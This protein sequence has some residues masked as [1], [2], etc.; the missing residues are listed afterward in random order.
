MNALLCGNLSIFKIRCYILKEID[1]R[2]N[3]SLNFKFI[4]TKSMYLVRPNW[5]SI[6]DSGHVNS[7]LVLSNIYRRCLTWKI[8]IYMRKY[9]EEMWLIWTLMNYFGLKRNRNSSITCRVDC[10]FG[11]VIA[12]KRLS[13]LQREV[14]WYDK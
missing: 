7:Y 12:K 8:R 13:Q 4:P 10:K 6:V 9:T 3:V 1:Y 14:T 5:F 11:F 2:Y